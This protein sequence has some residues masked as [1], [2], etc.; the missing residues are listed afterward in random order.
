MNRKDTIAAG[1][2]T[3]TIMLDQGTWNPI[4]AGLGWFDQFGVLNQDPV[5]AVIGIATG[6]FVAAGIGLFFRAV[7]EGLWRR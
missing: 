6:S 5:I 7:L 4:L 1:L 2:T 3:C